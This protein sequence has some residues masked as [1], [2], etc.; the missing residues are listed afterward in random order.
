[1]DTSVRVDPL[2]DLPGDPNRLAR[3]INRVSTPGSAPPPVLRGHRWL[4]EHSG[5]RI[6]H[7]LIGAPALLLYTTGRRSGQRRCSALVY[8][9]DSGRIILAASNDGADQSP[10]WF[11]NLQANPSVELQVGTRHL[12][13]QAV[14]IE[15]SHPGYLHL[16]EVMNGTNNRRYDA[17][18]AKTSRPIPLVVVTPGQDQ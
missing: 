2:A 14:V 7:G 12:S 18:Q 1:M 11:H 4:Y 5:G 13:G 10:A 3:A 9:R 17:Y 8:G 6:G 16:W 15:S